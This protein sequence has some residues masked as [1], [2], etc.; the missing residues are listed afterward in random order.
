MAVFCHLVGA[1][2]SGKQLNFE[3]FEAFMLD[4]LREHLVSLPAA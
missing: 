3:E 2:A 4:L 1:S